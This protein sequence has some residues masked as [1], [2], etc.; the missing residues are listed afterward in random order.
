VQVVITEEELK[1]YQGVDELL[2]PDK[3][4]VTPTAWDY[5]RTHRISLI[6]SGESKSVR[7]RASYCPES[8]YSVSFVYQDETQAV[9]GSLD[10]TVVRCAYQDERCSLLQELL[11]RIIERILR[12]AVLRLG[13]SAEPEVLVTIVTK[14]LTRLGY[15]V[16]MSKGGEPE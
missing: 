9:S 3:A 2:L 5:A 1:R 10:Q 14:T 6:R 7:S 4:V 11:N 12:T 16:V 15:D 13:F 8:P